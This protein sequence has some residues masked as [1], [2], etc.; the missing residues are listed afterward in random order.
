MRLN[1]FT[2]YRKILFV[3]EVKPTILILKIKYLF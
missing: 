2:Y 1:N 3:Q